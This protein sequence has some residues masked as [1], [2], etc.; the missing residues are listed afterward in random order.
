MWKNR[1]I[2]DRLLLSNELPRSAFSVQRLAFWR[3]G[4]WSAQSD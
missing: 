1:L 2:I 3:F 4:V